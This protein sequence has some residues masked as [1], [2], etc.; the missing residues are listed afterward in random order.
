VFA[1]PLHL[2]LPRRGDLLQE[3]GV[4]LAQG[5]GEALVLEEGHDHLA[6]PVEHQPPAR[7]E[8][9]RQGGRGSSTCVAGQEA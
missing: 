9:R 8:L 6:G 2:L 5:A 7:Q 1:R 3:V 4:A